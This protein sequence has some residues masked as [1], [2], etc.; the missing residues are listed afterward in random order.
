MKIGMSRLITD[1]L[2]IPFFSLG[3]E[4]HSRTVTLT[5]TW[6]RTR[7]GT[8]VPDWLLYARRPQNDTGSPTVPD[9]DAD[10]ER[11]IETNG[12][13]DSETEGVPNQNGNSSPSSAGIVI[14]AVAEEG[15]V[16][17]VTGDHDFAS[18]AGDVA[19]EPTQVRFSIILFPLMVR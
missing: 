18:G 5:Y 4:V 15:E 19:T 12:K 6:T 3:R 9:T 14:P 17:T 8:I 13:D 2:S 11:G 10:V 16:V 1:G 7:T